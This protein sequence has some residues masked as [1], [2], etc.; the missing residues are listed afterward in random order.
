MY[1]PTIDTIL[2]LLTTGL[3]IFYIK[4]KLDENEEIKRAFFLNFDFFTS[5]FDIYLQE[6]LHFY[7]DEDKKQF[8]EKT[9]IMNDYL[10]TN[11]QILLSQIQKICQF[12]GDFQ[13]K[14]DTKQETD[15]VETKEEEEPPKPI[16]FEEKY[17]EEY[18]K[19]EEIELNQERLE[20]LKNS[21]LIETT[22]LGNVVM[23]YD[24][25]RETFIYYSDSTIP[26]LSL[27]HI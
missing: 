13:L 4:K 14:P 27:I 7:T 21:I 19:A 17:K 8:I 20:Q 2:N 5:A 22:P 18:K 16:L 1:F 25:S 26:Y 11:G 15:D 9:T 24:T 12:I 10:V 23:Y 6:N 3:F